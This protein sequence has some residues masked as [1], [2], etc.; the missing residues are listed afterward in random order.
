MWGGCAKKK[1]KKKKK[2]LPEIKNF[3]DGNAERQHTAEAKTDEVKD[4]SIEIFQ[5]KHKE[6]RNE[7]NNLKSLCK[8]LVCI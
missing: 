8:H 3:F 5:L 6:K 4:R 2:K 1:K 7:K